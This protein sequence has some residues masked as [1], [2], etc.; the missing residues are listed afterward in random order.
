MSWGSDCR[1]GECFGCN[2]F[3]DGWNEGF[4]VF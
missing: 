1:F 3:V 2:G 4:T